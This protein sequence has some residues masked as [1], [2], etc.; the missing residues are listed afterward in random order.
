M[1][2]LKPLEMYAHS[3]AHPPEKTIILHQALHFPLNGFREQHI[4]LSPFVHHLVLF[5]RQFKCIIC[6]YTIEV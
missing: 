3:L 2:P 6:L 5:S 4:S 1:L